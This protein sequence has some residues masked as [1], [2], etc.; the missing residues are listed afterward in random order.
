MRRAAVL[1]ALCMAATNAAAQS[2][3]DR[4]V[5]IHARDIALRD[6][7][8]R[9]ALL[10]NIRLSYSGDNLPLDRRVSVD[11]DTAA[12][13]EVLGDLLKGYPIVPVTVA[14]DHVVLRPT[15]A[16]MVDT[17]AG[18]IT[19][20]DRVVVTGSLIGASERPL[21]I[22]LDVVLGRDLE[23]RNTNALSEVMS[24]SVPGV[25]MW[26]QTPTALLGRYGSIR[27]ASSFGLSF[28]KIYIDGIEVAN[29]LL[30]TQITPEVVERVEI[31]RGPQ[32]AALYGSDAISGVV[33]IISRHEGVGPDGS[34]A[35][36]RSSMG[37]TA[38]EYTR[39]S[40]SVQEHLLAIRGGSNLRSAGVTLGGS[41]SGQYIPNADSRELRGSADTRLIGAKSK[42]TANLRFHRKDAGVP[43]SP[44]LPPLDDSIVSDANPQE[45]RM[46][47][48]GSTLTLVPTER[49]TYTLTAGLDGYRLTNVSND[50]SPIPS[51]ADTELRNASGEAVRGTL[52]ASA[53][54]TL[55]SADRVGTT[56][57]FGAE[58]SDLLDRTLREL[59]PDASSDDWSEYGRRLV[60]G[61]SSSTGALVQA[62]LMFRNT[63]YLTTGIR[64]E[65]IA[66]SYGANQDATLPLVGAALVHD[67]NFASVKLRAGYGKGIRPARSTMHVATREPKRTLRNLTL[68][69]EEQSGIEIGADVRLGRFLG[70][71]VTRF[72]QLVSGLIQTVTVTR[73]TSSGPG[74]ESSWFQLQNVGEITN[75]GWETQA[76]LA[77]GT[78]S[79]SGAATFT[80]SR[81]RNL[82]TGYTGD[83]RPGDR[84]LTVPAT[85]LSGTIGWTGRRGLQLAS[86]VS[87][88]ANWINYDRLA[89]ANAL[90][91]QGMDSDDLTGDKLRRFWRSYGGATRWRAS[92]SVDVWRGMA[93]SVTG[94]NL[95]NYQH[96]EPDSITIVPG[97]TIAVGL[98]A[99]F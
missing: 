26:E 85:T 95:L 7:L 90:I 74:D 76:S 38:S 8:D 23:R 30:L 15:D 71:H 54:T 98:K 47:S 4:R 6:A 33:N 67:F 36:V 10:A 42:L 31:I 37:F 24:S 28:P 45:L 51:I 79:L 21:P 25:W 43:V 91:T 1:V 14:A 66:Q 11:R 81:V 58:R 2:P 34:R 88:A 64:R 48:G 87:R 12:V 69:P 57:T 94:E 70:V 32:G 99:R 92:G 22:A 50:L 16:A 77:L 46:Y 75:R 63:A 83:L 84:M 61:R 53:V 68:A 18:A 97:R 89:I 27:G 29:P 55:G 86:S 44:L 56:L 9:V 73:P 72:D 52:R 19:V 60:D 20:L 96:G 78:L 65:H 17:A 5:T 35:L 59:P 93:L 39:S 49:W 3:L 62:V 13:S 82:E 80:E 40:V 41:T